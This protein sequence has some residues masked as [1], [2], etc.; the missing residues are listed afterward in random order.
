M[1]TNENIWLGPGVLRRGPSSR[2]KKPV[3]PGEDIPKGFI[4]SNRL[5]QLKKSGKIV[6]SSQYA[7]SQAAGGKA[8][9][10]NA[11]IKISGL[12]SEIKRLTAE[13]EQ[14]EADKET[15]SS[16]SAAKEISEELDQLKSDHETLSS[17]NEQLKS[18]HETLS[19]ENE[20]LKADLKKAEK[21]GK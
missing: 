5:E 4:D 20:Q 10:E 6:T 19:S 9:V 14:L 16:D 18:D 7:K 2:A 12:E 21:G 8:P 15:L 11:A 17:E 3:M 13:N 1:S